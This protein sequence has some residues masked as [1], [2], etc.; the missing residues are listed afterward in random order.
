M[1][2]SAKY[3]RLYPNGSHRKEV[4]RVFLVDNYSDLD[5]MLTKRNASA[6]EV[7]RRLT[8][9]SSCL[10]TY[11]RSG[12]SIPAELVHLD[13]LKTKFGAYVAESTGKDV[14]ALGVGSKVKYDGSDSNSAKSFRSDYFKERNSTIPAGSIGE[15]VG[16]DGAEKVIVRFDGVTTYAWTR[17]WKPDS[18]YWKAG[19]RNV[20]EFLRTEIKMIDNVDAPIQN[21][22]RL[23]FGRIEAL[24]KTYIFGDKA[25]CGLPEGEK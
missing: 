21:K 3:L 5:S 13:A 11:A 10:E 6:E 22:M 4:V 8:V 9:L 14:S 24:T 15:V 20:A 2:L 1:E 18:Q 19:K 23:E 12:V 16:T 7:H 17:Q 25:Y